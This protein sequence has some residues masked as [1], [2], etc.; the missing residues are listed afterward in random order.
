MNVINVVKFLLIILISTVAGPVPTYD[1]EGIP[2]TRKPGVTS[3][4]A[5]LNSPPVPL[6]QP[7]NVPT[8]LTSSFPPQPTAPAPAAGNKFIFSNL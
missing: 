6:M 2:L 4:P 1:N 3:I 5:V 7:T 8:N